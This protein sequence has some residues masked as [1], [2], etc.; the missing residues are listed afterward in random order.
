MPPI[1]HLR[2]LSSLMFPDRGAQELAGERAPK[3]ADCGNARGFRWLLPAASFALALFLGA[4]GAIYSP[5]ASAYRLLGLGQNG[6]VVRPFAGRV[7]GAAAAGWLGRVTGLGVDW[8]FYFFGIVCLLVLLILM[9]RLLWSWQV[10]VALFAA[11]FLMPFWVDLFHDYYLPDLLHAAILAALLLSLAAG[12]MTLAMLLLFPAYVARESTQLIV[13]CLIFAGW[14]RVPA[15]A[16]A[17]GALAVVSGAWVSRHY[18]NLGAPAAQGTGTVSYLLGKAGWS[19]FHNIVGLPLWSN[20]L[21]ECKSPLGVASIPN[22]Y[23]LGAIRMVGLCPPS[24]WGPAR[25]L[26]AWFG[27]FGIGPALAIAFLRPLFSLGEASGAAFPARGKD[28]SVVD[29][30]IVAYRFCVIYGL[31]SFLL[32][33]LL[34]ASTDRLVEYAWPLFFVALPIYVAGC[35]GVVRGMGRSRAVWLLALHLV[36][37][38]MAWWAF[39]EQATPVYVDAGLAALV[40]NIVAYALIGPAKRARIAPPAAAQQ[41]A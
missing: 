22:G 4:P 8:G 28:G 2:M 25:V 34:G 27:V 12:R 30:R 18:G 6:S 32:A 5:D 7:L 24:A 37:C 41:T 13:L 1:S 15:R 38:W 9:A 17:A 21:P 14:R 36:V 19:F 31:S 35:P 39:R 33:P 29:G 10:S 26:L 11:I 23:H 20:I 16:V 40:L 3:L